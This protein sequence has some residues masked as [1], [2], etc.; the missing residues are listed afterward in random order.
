MSTGTE[1]GCR[2]ADR[3]TT[4]PVLAR[5]TLAAILAA[6]GAGCAMELPLDDPTTV[7]AD[8]PAPAADPTTAVVT[9]RFR[10]LAVDEAVNVEFY[11]TN[12]PLVSLPDDLFVERNLVTASV[13][14]AGTGILEPLREDTLE[15]PCTEHLVVG[16][17]G[18]T[19][20]DNE[21]GETRGAGVA[22]WAEDTALG[23]CGHKILFEFVNEFGT[24][25]TRVAIGN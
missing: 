9:I 2:R 20:L 5:V 11:A 14:V 21:T 4:V 8:D 25:T 3:T 18:G 1:R 15:F 17:L 7:P 24:F 6:G 23:L 12:D 16:T 13:G 19:F 10:N 22:R